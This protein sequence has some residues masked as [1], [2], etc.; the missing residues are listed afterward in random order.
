MAVKFK[1]SNKNENWSLKGL[2]WEHVQ[3]LS[4]LLMYTR[5]STDGYGN[6]ASEIMHAIEQNEGDLGDIACAIDVTFTRGE[7]E[8]KPAKNLGDN[9][10]IN[11]EPAW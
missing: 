2:E 9:V 4:A 11:L 1:Y 6:T 8:T 5:L 10:S 3:V 7:T